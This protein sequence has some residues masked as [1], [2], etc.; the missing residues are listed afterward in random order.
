MLL[1]HLSEIKDAI[2]YQLGAA[3]EEALRG[4][5]RVGRDGVRH[6]GLDVAR[7]AHKARNELEHEHLR[8]GQL[9]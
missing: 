8:L 5:R 3:L 9:S 2:S 6:D 4:D 7:A 1:G